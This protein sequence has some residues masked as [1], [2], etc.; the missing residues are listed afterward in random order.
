[1]NSFKTT[2]GLL[3]ILILLAFNVRQCTNNNQMQEDVDNLRQYETKAKHYEA[4]NGELIAYNTSLNTNLRTL[5]DDNAFIADM[6]ENMRI[7]KPSTIIRGKTETL[8]DS[9]FV[10]YD[11][12]VHIVNDSFCA[13]FH[14]NDSIWISI[15][16]WVNQ[17]G[18]F[19][20]NLKLQDDMLIVVGEKDNGF[21]RRDEYVVALRNANPH[22]HVD[23]LE[24][25]NI[26]PKVKFYDRLWFKAALFGAGTAVGILLSR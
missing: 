25:Y 23:E 9:V 17:D 12:P 7:Q 20:E 1:M 15:N 4:K 2:I 10:P 11:R 21:W 16:G 14:W 22:V 3:V 6:L 18:V 24:H 8:I 26:K 13:D 19:I 5:K